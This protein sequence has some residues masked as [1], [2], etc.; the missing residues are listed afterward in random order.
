MKKI[1]KLENIHCADCARALEETIK[2]FNGVKNAKIDFVTEKFSLEIDDECWEETFL[3]VKKLLKD[4]SAN[5]VLTEIDETTKETNI[6][7]HLRFKVKGVACPNCAS[8]IEESIKKLKEVITAKL[9]FLKGE[10]TIVLNEEN[11]DAIKKRIISLIKNIEPNIKLKEFNE[12]P[13]SKFNLGFSVYLM[14]VLLS[15]IVGIAFYGVISLNPT[16]Y[17]GLIV[18]SALLLGYKTYIT[19]VKMLLNKNINENLLVTISVFGAIVIGEHLEGLMVIALFTLGK[20]LEGKAVNKSRRDIKAL[21]N[22]K[23]EYARIKTEDGKKRILLEDIKVG[24]IIVIKAGEILGADGT[25]VSGEGY[26]DTKCITGESEPVYYKPGDD[27][28][29]GVMS[30]DTMLEVRVTKQY[31]EST[32]NKILELIDKASEKK[33]KT[34]TFIARFSKYYTLMVIALSVLTGI[35]TSLILQDVSTGIYRGLLFLVVSCPCA[36]AISVP[37]TYFSG[38]GNA[39][40][41]GILIKGT[42]YLDALHK[43]KVVAFDKTGTLTTGI[44]KVTAVEPVDDIYTK[45]EILMLSAIGEAGSTHAVAKAIRR[46]VKKKIPAYDSFREAV[47]EGV[48][49]EYDGTEYFLGRERNAKSIGSEV[50]LKKG[51]IIIGKIYLEDAIKETS[52]NA[53]CTLKSE[54]VKTI[55]LTGDKESVANN[56]ASTLGVDEYKAEMLPQEKF[57]Y[58]ENFKLASSERIAFVGDGLN[59]APSLKIA[60]VGVCMGINGSPASIEASDVVLVDD[61]P[62]KIYDAIKTSKF[63]KKIVLQNIIFA[64]AIKLACLVL[65]AVGLANMIMAVFADVGVTVL[66]ILN[67][68]RVLKYGIKKKKK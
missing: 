48:Y 60:D 55:I 36:F 13:K 2:S 62:I 22:I 34:E 16:I 50:T 53:I 19:A 27:I 26:V 67:S 66:A 10:L 52:K 25:V 37:L 56:I 11:T 4:F 47:G 51:N 18:V 58:I 42:R 40:R 61:D 63:T 29:S 6:Q 32:V 21:M 44:L 64:G 59:D 39:S 15:V 23:P 33:S 31:K 7:T 38:I 41:K 30:V 20:I 57:E 3:K 43:T 14:G 35:I 17:Y 9:D 68:L 8:K 24:D 49:F 46:E 54:G 65:G 45:D 12:E 5:V 28:L 1:F